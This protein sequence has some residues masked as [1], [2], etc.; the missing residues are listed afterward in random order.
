MSVGILGLGQWLPAEVRTNA[1]W[2][3]EFVT[4]SRSRALVELAD[5]RTNPNGDSIDRLVARYVEEEGGDPFFATERR[6]IAADDDTARM[7]EISAARAALDDAGVRGEDV[8]VVISVPS[9]PDRISL[10]PAPAIVHALGAQ[11]AFGIGLDG[12]CASSMGALDIAISYVESGRARYVLLT[13]SHLITRAHPL[14]HPV[15]PNLGDG[16]TA[17]VVG[18]TEGRGIVA[19]RLISHGEFY[20][21]VGL[22]R[23]PGDDAPW[24]Q[25]GG[26]ISLGAY[27]S[28]KARTLVQDTVR[29]GVLTVREILDRANMAPSDV[30][31]FSSVQPRRWV[32]HAIAEAVGLPAT[33]VVETFRELA[34]LGPCGPIANLN[35]ARRSGLLKSGARVVMYA[36]G[37]GFTRAAAVVEWS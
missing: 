5:V 25:P 31:V 1:A 35:A 13:Q 30:S 15:S 17:M 23:R 12:A 21:A 29:I 9:L 33:S 7:A 32:P 28:E 27:D 37:A 11:K 2:P 14:M 4:A 20:D 24:W 22:R 26:A 19:T 34:H 8:E 18:K 6:H 36:Q 10:S 3:E 16:A